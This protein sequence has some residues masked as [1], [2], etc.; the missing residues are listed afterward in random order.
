MHEYLF[1]WWTKEGKH[2][3]KVLKAMTVMNAKKR[4]GKLTRHGK[5][6]RIDRTY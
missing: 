2:K 5:K 4:F 6:V 1:T 3:S